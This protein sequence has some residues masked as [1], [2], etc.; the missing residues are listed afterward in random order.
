PAED[1]VP[2]A[3]YFLAQDFLKIDS[4]SDAI[5]ALQ[6]LVEE[7]PR[8]PYGEKGK[9]QLEDLVPAKKSTKNSKKK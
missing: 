2:A 1:M 4:K 8:T 3:L 9:D 5:V 7:H 6:K